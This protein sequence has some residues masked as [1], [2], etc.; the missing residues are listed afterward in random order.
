[1]L[2]STAKLRAAEA[3]GDY[4]TRLALQRKSSRCPSASSGIFIVNR[5]MFPSATDGWRK[6]SITKK[7][8]GQ[9]Q[10][11]DRRLESEQLSA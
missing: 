3:A 2:E 10:V 8:S 4:T 5:K 1:L 6:Q 9:T 7:C 11:K